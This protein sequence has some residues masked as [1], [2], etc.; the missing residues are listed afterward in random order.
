MEASPDFFHAISST[1]GVNLPNIAELHI[2][3]ETWELKLDAADLGDSAIH[4]QFYEAKI[5]NGG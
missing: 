3:P 5:G 2:W 4:G 1:L